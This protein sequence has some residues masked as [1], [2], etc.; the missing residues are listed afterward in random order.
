MSTEIFIN[1][2]PVDRMGEDGRLYSSGSIKAAWVV[3]QIKLPEPPTDRQ[4][5]T[6]YDCIKHCK[7]EGRLP[8]MPGV[9]WCKKYGKRLVLDWPFPERLQECEATENWFLEWQTVM[10]WR[11]V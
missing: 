5:G 11:E 2:K 1:G 7:Y 4:P 3:T 8:M 10:S 9:L 6:C